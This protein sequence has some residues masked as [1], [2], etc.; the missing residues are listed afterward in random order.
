LNELSDNSGY[1]FTKEVP[2]GRLVVGRISKV[3]E[4]ADGKKRFCYSTRQ[5]LVVFGVG[6]VDASKLNEKDQVESIVMAIAEGKAFGQIKGSYI[7]LKIKEGPTNLKVGD[8]VVSSLNKVTKEK[9]SS[10]FVKKVSQNDWMSDDQKL[11]KSI[12]ESV[13]E[14]AARELIFLRNQNQSK[15]EGK[16]DFDASHLD[17]KHF[18]NREEQ[19]AQ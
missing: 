16:A 2:V 14:E 1:D 10:S 8:H 13:Q 12:Y 4:S 9:I 3:E 5:S 7:K 19:L 11:V 6:C 15:T 18:M 17:Q